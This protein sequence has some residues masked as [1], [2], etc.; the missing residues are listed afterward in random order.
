MPFKVFGISGLRGVVGEELTA[1]SCAR[2]AAVF[3]ARLG[4]GPVALGRDARTTGPML[5]AA[6]GAGL[7]GVGREVH[8]LGIC[9]TPTVLHH[10]RQRGLAGALVVTASH[11]PEQWNGLKFVGPAGRFLSPDEFAGF[12]AAVEPGPAAGVG[13]QDVGRLEPVADAIDAHVAAIVSH[14][15]FAGVKEGARGRRVGIDAVNGAA[16][17]A[18][19]RLVEAFGAESVLLNCDTGLASAGFPRRPEPTPDNLTDLSRLVRQQKLDLGVGFDPDGDRAGFIDQTGAALPEELTIC[20]ACEWLLPGLA[21]QGPVVINLSTSRA[22][23]DVCARHK[24]EVVRAPVGEAAVV[25]RMRE[26]E[27]PLGGEGNGGVIFPAVNETRDGLVALACALGLA[28]TGRLSESAAAVPRYRMLK[29]VLDLGAGDFVAGQER[30]R[31]EFHGAPVDEQDGLRFEL[32]DGWV[33][34]RPSNTEPIVRVLVE[35]RSADPAELVDRVRAALINE[36]GG[37]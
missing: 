27:S 37:N 33:H 22:V 21:D 24:V 36:D 30:L 9:P 29:T 8:D 20:L 15:A 6:A 10:V 19:A 13:W 11:N 3:G 12:R 18:A 34:V 32:D 28:G 14:P 2:V 31:A 4:P 23:E 35:T 16:S 7:V 1:E 5:A 25:A 26:L 17:G